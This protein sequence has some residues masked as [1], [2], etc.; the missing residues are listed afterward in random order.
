M[1]ARTFPCRPD[2]LKRCASDSV[3]D[4]RGRSFMG[5]P[6]QGI[7]EAEEA[8]LSDGQ[9]V[10]KVDDQETDEA[11][12]LRVLGS[13]LVFPIGKDLGKSW[14]AALSDCG[15]L[16]GKTTGLKAKHKGALSR[17][18]NHRKRAYS[19]PTQEQT[20]PLEECRLMIERITT[21]MQS[22]VEAS[23]EKVQDSLKLKHA[24]EE[25]LL[26]SRRVF[27]NESAE[28][29]MQ[30]EVLRSVKLQLSG[31]IKELESRCRTLEDN[32]ERCCGKDICI[33]CMEAPSNAVF[34]QCGHMVC[35]ENCAV[36]L[37]HCP[38]CREKATDWMKIYRS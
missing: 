29:L 31:Q 2:G 13:S 12:A 28:L 36:A 9:I 35:C 15:P 32:F 38:M 25:E 3:I 17:L 10:G 1:P 26:H 23:Q 27:N 21:K 33:V 6:A 22:K 4:L 7:K 11:A 16:V 18:H 37:P 8:T 34:T 5:L 14:E 24:A 19:D 20:V 30:V